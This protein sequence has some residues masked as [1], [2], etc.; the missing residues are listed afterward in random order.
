MKKKKRENSAII[1]PRSLSASCER[2]VLA[3]KCIFVYANE[4]DTYGGEG[5]GATMKRKKNTCVR[6][7]GRATG[8]GQ[9]PPTWTYMCRSRGRV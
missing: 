7:A 4:K 5:G 8:H 9:R 3:F 1:S 6:L 2:V